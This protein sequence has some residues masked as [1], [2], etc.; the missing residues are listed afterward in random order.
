MNARIYD[1]SRAALGLYLAFLYV[2][3]LPWAAEI[4]TSSGLGEDAGQL[5][6]AWE[7]PAVHALVVTGLVAALGLLV[8]RFT[9]A[10]AVVGMVV[11]LLLR[12]LNWWIA[13]SPESAF[14]VW[15]LL[16][17]IVID[18]SSLPSERGKGVDL[19]CIRLFFVFTL[20]QYAVFGY[21]KIVENGTWMTGDALLNI[22]RIS[23]FA[24]P[25][26]GGLFDHVP[27]IVLTSFTYGSMALEL[28][29]PLFYFSR[30]TRELFWVLITAMHVMLLVFTALTEISLAM[31]VSH[32]FLLDYRWRIVVWASSLADRLA[33]LA[34]RRLAPATRM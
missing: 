2:R 14:V 33:R 30:T 5:L 9:R 8:R 34:P 25:W 23:P 32:L 11:F 27:D 3:V 18:R 1:L 10:C 17:L 7:V 19:L 26:F 21:Q 29:A 12:E 16:M 31:I 6:G 15:S 13:W 28:V 20:L 22:L 24:R 4:Y